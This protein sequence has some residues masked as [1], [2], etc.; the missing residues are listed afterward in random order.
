[1]N[2]QTQNKQNSQCRKMSKMIVFAAPLY[3]HNVT[4]RTGVV[5]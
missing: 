3:Q 2:E 1:M 5:A 4:E